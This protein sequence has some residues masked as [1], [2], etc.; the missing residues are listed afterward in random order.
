M[1]F[2]SLFVLNFLFIIC[3]SYQL[4]GSTNS[5]IHLQIHMNESELKGVNSLQLQ[6][7]QYYFHAEPDSLVGDTVLLTEKQIRRKRFISAI[8]SFPLPFGIIGLHRVYLGSEP[9]IPLVYIGTL[10]GVFGILPLIDFISI[11][12]HKKID[13]FMN[14]KRLMMWVK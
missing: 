4:L 12:R 8:L 14:N 3:S 11:C 9:Y 6:D 5:N 13:Y 2:F 1:K 10:G 7:V